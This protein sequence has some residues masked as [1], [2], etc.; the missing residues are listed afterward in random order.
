M[1]GKPGDVGRYAQRTRVATFFQRFEVRP[2]VTE[3]WTGLSIHQQ[4]TLREKNGL[5]AA[6]KGGFSPQSFEPFFRNATT[7]ASATLFAAIYG[8]LGRA[9]QLTGIHDARR[10]PG[11]VAAVALIDAYLVYV[12]CN[13]LP[14]VDH[15]QAVLLAV[16][17]VSGNKIGFE[18]CRDCPMGLLVDREGEAI[19]HCNVCREKLRQRRR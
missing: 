11:V 5:P 1:H 13:P 6:G 14:C 10:L 15:E 17:C 2:S 12:A 19:R 8:L 18:R 9:G 7:R 3:R 16:G 4:E